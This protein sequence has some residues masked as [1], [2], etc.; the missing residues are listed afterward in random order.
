M[1][2]APPGL[3][4]TTEATTVFSEAGA[5]SDKDPLPFP[6]LPASLPPLARPFGYCPPAPPVPPPD[7]LVA[8]SL[9]SSR[10]ASRCPSQITTPRAPA[11]M[12]P[13][14]SLPQPPASLPHLL[15]P[16][17]SRPALASLSASPWPSI[18]ASSEICPPLP[19]LL[20]FPRASPSTADADSSMLGPTT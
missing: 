14:P 13:V 4:A 18:G 17:S 12:P 5:S 8:P 20:P 9:A 15:F 2:A 11:A 7:L 10:A 19:D 6:P 1:L 3:A 16:P